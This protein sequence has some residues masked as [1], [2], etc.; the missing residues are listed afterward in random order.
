M[1][2]TAPESQET[3]ITTASRPTFQDMNI[4]IN[5]SWC[6]NNSGMIVLSRKFSSD[7]LTLL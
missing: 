5:N 4:H 3:A 2:M 7:S 1:M 6:N